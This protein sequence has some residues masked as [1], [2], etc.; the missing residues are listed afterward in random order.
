[1]C[2]QPVPQRGVWRHDGGE[3]EE[4]DEVD[5]AGEVGEELDDRDLVHL[6]LDG[7]AE[8]EPHGRE[9]DHQEEES[10]H[11]GVAPVEVPLPD[12]L[13]VLLHHELRDHHLLVALDQNVD[14][15]SV[16]AVGRVQDGVRGL[17]VAGGDDQLPGELLAEVR[18]LQQVLRT[19][20][21]GDGHLPVDGGQLGRRV[22][23][24]GRHEEEVLQHLEVVLL[25]DLHQVVD[26]LVVVEQRV[27]V[28]RVAQQVLHHVLVPL[29]ARIPA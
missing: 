10:Q 16:A 4:E 17:H 20:L 2:C 24:G 3:R 8:E 28:V 1:M 22:G 5:V 21:L 6:V 19:L 15:G 27:G 7:H 26:E 18:G 29:N 13:Q 12:L 25:G 11:L 9:E 14:E 23:R